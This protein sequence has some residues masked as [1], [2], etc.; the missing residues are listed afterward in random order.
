MK[1]LSVKYIMLT[2]I[3]AALCYIARL[4]HIPIGS[5]PITLQTTAVIVTSVLLPPSSAFLA[6]VL[7]FLLL[8]LLGGG[9]ALFLEPSFGF[10]IGF[11][12][13]APILSFI[14]FHRPSTLALIIGMIIAE[15]IF[16]STGIPYL[17]YIL[18]TKGLSFS[19]LAICKIG[20]FP[21]IIPDM[22]KGVIALSLITSL[23]K[24]HLDFK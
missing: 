19:W 24:H 2:S 9:T 7:H 11:I 17:A 6:Q 14:T 1:S 3:F 12:I 21:F 20:L 4:I 8:F 15:I 5:V 23:K 10:I 16:Y 18:S 22:I 13:A